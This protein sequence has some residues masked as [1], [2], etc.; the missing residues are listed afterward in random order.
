M[1]M[2]GKASKLAHEAGDKLADA[3][4]HAAEAL[5]ETGEQLLN[6]E[7]QLVANCRGYVRDNPL[8]AIGIAAAAGFMVSR[9]LNNR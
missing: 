4:N 7:Q 8:A 9:L 1:N 6:A 3:G 2:T 5:E